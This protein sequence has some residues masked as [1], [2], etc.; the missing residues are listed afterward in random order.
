MSSQAAQLVLD[1]PS[2]RGGGQAENCV[3]DSA[4]TSAGAAL[5]DVLPPKFLTDEALAE[6]LK[7]GQADALTTLF[8]RYSPR[9][10]GVARRV[11]RNEAEAEDVVQQVFLDVF[12]SIDQFEP[13]KGSFQTWILMFA[14]QRTLNRRRHLFANRA[15][16]TQPLEEMDAASEMT[17][18]RARELRLSVRNA[19]CAL[20]PH[21]RRTIEWIYFE[22]LT[23]EEVAARTGE[24]VS[25]VRHNLYRGLEKL[26]QAT[27]SG[28]G[29][30][31]SKG[32]ES[33][34]GSGTSVL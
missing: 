21:Q 19:L 11:L 17:L 33:G 3:S 6:Q 4:G 5:L 8:Q 10:F 34:H 28:K 20:K 27:G 9:L 18:D 25:M 16:V 2:P 7:Q 23:A 13:C 15:H 14:Y 12:R 24:T 32:K 31:I 22:G 29:A 26:R 1:V 30:G